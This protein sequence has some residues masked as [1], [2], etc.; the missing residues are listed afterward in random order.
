VQCVNNIKFLTYFL[1]FFVSGCNQTLTNTS[2]EILSPYY[3]D[4]YPLNI[5][6][7]Y[8]ITAPADHHISL[9]LEFLDLAYSVNCTEDVLEVWDGFLGNLA[10]IGR[11]CGY[12]FSQ[13]VH[14]KGN[15][16][17]LSFRSD[18]AGTRRGYKLK[19]YAVKSG[20]MIIKVFM[21]E[22]VLKRSSCPS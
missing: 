3:P 21:D 10:P 13:W 4:N 2:G 20:M 14:S 5:Y 16:L 6:C 22:S 8:S 17:S 9:A 15:K 1:I 12:L 7:T 19:Y 11:Y 18:M